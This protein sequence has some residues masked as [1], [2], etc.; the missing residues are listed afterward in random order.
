M[1]HKGKAL[2]KTLF[3]KTDMTKKDIGEQANCSLVSLNKWIKEGCWE[4]LKEAEKRAAAVLTSL[5]EAC[6]IAKVDPRE[7][8]EDVMG[9]INNHPKDKLY[10]LL[11]NH[12]AKNPP[13]PLG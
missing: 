9:R 13:K 5:I 11:P 6:R 8:L 4:E 12:W 7:Y 1:E 3:F 10:E 2:A